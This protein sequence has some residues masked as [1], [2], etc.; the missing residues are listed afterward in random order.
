MVVDVAVV[1]VV[2]DVVAIAAV[3]QP[4]QLLKQML[5]SDKFLISMKTDNRKSS[6]MLHRFEFCGNAKHTVSSTS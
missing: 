2:A 6:L 5:N 3:V 4:P 1:V